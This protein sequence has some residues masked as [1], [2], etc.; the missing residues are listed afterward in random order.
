MGVNDLC[1]IKGQKTK[2]RENQ[3]QGDSTYST[4]MMGNDLLE[5]F[6]EWKGI[7]IP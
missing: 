4:Y 1:V 5:K 7:N 6:P 2:S 3:F